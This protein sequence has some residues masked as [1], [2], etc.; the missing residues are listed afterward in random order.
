MLVEMMKKKNLVNQID[1]VYDHQSKM[2]KTTD[3]R[4]LGYKDVLRYKWKCEKYHQTFP[5]FKQ[6]REHRDEI[7]SY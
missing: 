6:L 4:L 1:F 5:S 7:H 2:Y 3:G